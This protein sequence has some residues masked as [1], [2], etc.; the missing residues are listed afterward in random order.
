MARIN[1]E[2]SIHSDPRFLFIADSIGRFQAMGQLVYLIKLAQRYWG[3]GKQKIPNKV[4][5]ISGFSELF[6]ES[7][8]VESAEDGFYLSGSEDHFAWLVAKIENG[9]KGGRPKSVSSKN[10]DLVKPTDNLNEASQS[11][12]NPLTLTLTPTLTLNNIKPKKTA[13]NLESVYSMYPLKRGKSR[14]IAKLQKAITSQEQYENLTRAI[15]NYA[16]ICKTENTKPKYIKHFSTFAG[17]W[18]DY[19]DITVPKTRDEILIEL[20][21]RPPGAKTDEQLDKEWEDARA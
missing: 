5:N 15:E 7:G 18:E 8:F 10:E 4:Y 16:A 3:E 2:E 14:G 12:K 19:V 20:F 21:A 11:Y 13:F 9:K 6:I 17:E 1:I